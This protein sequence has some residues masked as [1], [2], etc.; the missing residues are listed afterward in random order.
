MSTQ[1]SVARSAGVIGSLTGVSRVLGF[2]RDLVI[3]AAFGTSIA[4]E[5]F[6]V[7]FK[8]PNLLRDL[9]GEG[10]ANAAFVPVLTECREKK[11]GDFWGLVSTLF[12]ILAGVL[13]ALTL[14][15]VVFAPFIIRVVAPGFVASAD[16]GKYPL[17]IEL[18]RAI[19]PY[20]FLIGLS[21]LAMGVLNTLKEFTASAIGPIL[22]NLSMIFWGFFFEKT[23]GPM[24]LVI[25]VLCGG[26]LQLGCQVPA[27]LKK[28]FRLR[29]PAF[30]HG[31]IAKIGR[32]LVPRAFGSALYHIN[33]F[34]DTILASFERIVGAGGQS[35]LYYSN[36]LFQLPLAIFGVAMAQALLPTFSSQMVRED[37]EGFKETFS[38]AVRTLMLVVLPASVGL[39]AL[40]E[41]IIRIIFERG[42]FD[43]YSTAITSSAL[44]FYAF[45]LLSCC[46]IKVFVNA[47][48]A[49]HDTRTPVKITFVSLGLNILFCLVLMKPLKIGGLALASSLSA[50]V[51]MLLLYRALRGRIGALDEARILKAF[52][53]M[54]SAALLMGFA[55][56]FY[57]ELVLEAQLESRRL[58]QAASLLGGIFLSI[59]VYFGFAFLLRVEE[60]KR[61]FSWRP[62]SPRT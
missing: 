39:I 3:A 16:A 4:A 46:F 45:G 47:F 22:L 5:A 55:A 11:P 50:T 32:L 21:A 28:G 6:V 8:L 31:A 37:L 17:T 10:A 60:T 29:P 30:H 14:L 18:T 62:G 19:F 41:P 13:A 36:R 2:V 44:Y 25:G 59:L 61:I 49:M 38:F 54:A 35:A 27:L 52:L 20:I 12:L 1:R 40:S 24:A 51:N 42:R 15:G 43:A 7:S 34:V 26:V 58:V 56:L 23:Y 48:Y 57:N 33:V 9:V 53:K